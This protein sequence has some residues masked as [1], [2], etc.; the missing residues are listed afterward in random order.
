MPHHRLPR[1]AYMMLKSLDDVQ[2][3]TWA[4]SIRQLLGKFGFHYIWN[5][6]G[7]ANEVSFLEVFEARVKEFYK[8][9]WSEN[10]QNSSKLAVYC[11][12]KN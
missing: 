11:T 1:A 12:F 3:Q 5:S 9:A 8:N 6:Q 10:M 4:T 7:V 2:R